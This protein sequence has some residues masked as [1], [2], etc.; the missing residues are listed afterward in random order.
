MQNDRAII[1]C[2]VLAA[3]YIAIGIPYGFVL[4]SA[5]TRCLTYHFFHANLFHLLANLFCLWQ[6]IRTGR[7]SW[8]RLGIAF[9]VASIVPLIYDQHIVGFSNILYALTGLSF[10]S[11]SKQTKWTILIVSAAMIPFPHIAGVPHF[12]S[13]AFGIALAFAK[14]KI[15]QIRSDSRSATYR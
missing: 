15:D 7:A 1:S 13:L 4:W 8:R 10:F 14:N 2:G 9:L 12:I 11:F 3:I 5:E 6:I